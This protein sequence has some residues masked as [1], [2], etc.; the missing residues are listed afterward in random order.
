MSWKPHRLRWP[1]GGLDA[2]TLLNSQP[3]EAEIQSGLVAETPVSRTLMVSDLVAS[4]QLVERLGDQQAAALFWRHDRLARKLLHQHDGQ[5][6][7]KSDGFLLLF[8]R[9]I[10]ALRYALDYHR[11]LDRL[12]L[13]AGVEMTSRV[14]V[15]LGQILLHDNPADEVALGAKP[16]EVEGL[17]KIVAARL[18]AL[19]GG[20]QTLLTRATF[21]TLEAALHREAADREGLQWQA[22][23]S[24]R[25]KGL[26]HEVDV[27]EVGIRGQAPFHPPSAPRQVRR[28]EAAK[29]ARQE[30]RSWAPPA[31]PDRPYPVLLPYTHPALLTGRSRDLEKLQRLLAMPVPIL[32]MYA[33]S[34]AGKSSLLSGGLVPLLRARGRP[35]AFDRHPYEAGLGSRLIGDL[36]SLPSSPRRDGLGTGVGGWAHTVADGSW[37]GFLEL[38]LEAR[39]L[40]GKPPI[41]VLDQFEDLMRRRDCR[42]VRAQLGLL[43]AATVARKGGLDCHPCRWLLAYR[44]EYHGRVVAWLRDVLAEARAQSWGDIDG[45][46]HDLSGAERFQGWPLQPLGAPPPRADPMAEAVRA[47][48]AAIEAPLGLTLADGKPRYPWRFEDGGAERLARAFAEA[49][50]AHPEASLTPELQVVL[51]HLLAEANARGPRGEASPVLIRVPQEPAGLIEEALADHLKRS[52]EATFPTGQADALEK[53][54]TALLVLR[55][56]ADSMGEGL[57]VSMLNRAL[58]EGGEDLLERLSAS[59][60]RLV[61]LKEQPQGW[62]CAL[63][64]DSI[65]A[66]VIEMVEQEGQLGQ[67][68]I[69]S[70]LLALRRFVAVNSALE[71]RDGRGTRLPRGYFRRIEANA[72]A[73]LWDEQRREWWA[74]CRRRR[75]ADGWR[76][77]AWA[78]VV[79][80]VLGLLLVGLWRQVQV[81]AEHQTLL[82]NISEGEPKVALAALDGLASA[83]G[84]DLEPLR[85]HLSQRP[86]PMDILEQ[87]LEGI[88]EHRRGAAVLRA[89][90]VA[91]PILAARKGQARATASALWALDFFSGQSAER[92]AELRR[93]LLSPPMPPPIE[94]EDWILVPAGTFAMGTGPEE[95]L[96]DPTSADE[97]PRHPVTLGA[98]RI[99]RHEVTH[100]EFRRL[101]PDHDGR[102]DLPASHV[103]WYTAY[104]YAAWLGGRLPTEAEWEY[105]ARAGCAELYCDRHGEPTTVDRVAWYRSNVIDRV[106]F[107]ASP[108]A[109]MGKEPNPWGLYDVF[110]N[111]REWTADWYGPYSADPQ[112]DPKGPPSGQ[113]RVIRGGDYWHGSR[114]SRARF[115]D[116]RPPGD[117][118]ASIGFRVVLPGG[119]P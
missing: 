41:L 39:R 92:A 40:A 82:T 44:H 58:G 48:R 33:Q 34:G 114:R 20:R 109:V 30:L 7:D 53:R 43:L 9:P 38:L 93:A 59:T 98:F 47:F 31:Y 68:L 115:R 11:V 71:P 12:A 63:S 36:L 117:A 106:T 57:P 72:A 84:A 112:V 25:L 67:R 55:E 17:A 83:E 102:E 32:G 23:G 45:L 85:R 104:V 22:H 119:T 16:V 19:A 86:A 21:E 75:R 42:R 50:I 13:E 66:A 56:L 61:V 80:W 24:F 74:A 78:A 100:G 105:A 1:W 79:A 95:R 27:V 37:R 26:A 15:H 113:R 73:L 3:Q 116:T 97:R 69:D 111:V 96:E 14:G 87:G 2:E 10:D 64:H 89:V 103:D 76:A 107:A 6:I 28:Q 35:V 90:E 60:T 46:P 49:R 99:L 65:A 118:V 52:L 4:T 110:G 62:Y 70:D 101:F 91:A 29:P 108:K 5:E 81:S 88:A 51:A 8:E 77:A 18:M 94:T 54:T